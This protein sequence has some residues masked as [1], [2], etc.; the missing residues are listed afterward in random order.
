LTPG[1]GG[2]SAG[3]TVPAGT[4]GG[5]A[6]SN[7]NHGA[8]SNPDPYTYVSQMHFTVHVQ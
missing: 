6:A 5:N 4:N 3:V 7:N 2:A 8:P 1:A